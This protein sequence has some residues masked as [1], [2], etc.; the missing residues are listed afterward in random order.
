MTGGSSFIVSLPKEW[1]TKNHIAKN[2]PVGL[3]IQPDGTLTISPSISESSEKREKIFFVKPDDNPEHLFRYLIAAY[4]DGFS[5][6]KITSKDKLPYFVRNV[7]RQFIHMTIGQEVEEEADN[8]IR[9]IDL[10]NPAEMKFE[11]TIKRMFVMVKN[12][13]EDAMEAFVSANAELSEDII[14]RDNDVDRLHWLLSRQKML[15]MQ[16]INLSRKMGISPAMVTYYYDISKII[17]R[18][19]DHAVKISENMLK[20]NGNEPNNEFRMKISNLSGRALALFSHS[21]R[22]F[23]SKNIEDSNRIIEEVRRLTREC[24]E[25]KKTTFDMNAHIALPLGLII[26]SIERVGEYAEDIAEITIN[27]LVEET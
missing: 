21:I 16:N 25:I 20:L 26:S 8:F 18:I 12:M 13:H 2:D 10:L 14:N 19:A 7:V 22:E 1:I 23:Y 11:N 6:I 27:Y 17:E 24:R 9:I 3:I 5:T 15:I 4:I